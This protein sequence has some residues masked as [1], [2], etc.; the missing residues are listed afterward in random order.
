MESSHTPLIG[1][2]DLPPSGQ[3]DSLDQAL[4]R[5]LAWTGAARW[6]AQLATWTATILVARLLEKRDFGIWAGAGVYIGIVTLLSE[7]GIGASVVMLRDLTIRQIAQVNGF[8]IATGVAGTLLTVVLAHP[9]SLFYR[10]PEVEGVMLAMAVIFFISSFRIVPL[11]LLQKELRFRRLAAIDAVRALL[12]ASILVAAAAAGLRY[13]ALVVGAISGELAWTLMI[14]GHRRHGLGWPRPSSIRHALSFSTDVAVGRLSWYLYSNSDFMI[15]GRRLGQ[16]ALGAYSLA[17]NLASVPVEKVSSIVNSVTPAFL[18][19]VQTDKA[20]LRRYLLSLTQ[21]ISLLAF[22]AAIGLALVADSFVTAVLGPRWLP[23]VIPLRLLAA[24][25]TVRSIGP[26]LTP[27]LNAVGETRFA[28]VNNVFALVLMPAGFLV[29]SRWGT[30]GIAAG[31]L[32]VHPLILAVLFRRVSSRIDLPAVEY[33]R[34][35]WPALSATIAMATVVVG[36]RWTLSSAMAPPLALV[37]EGVAG[38]ITYAVLLLAFHR[39][40]VQAFRRILQLARS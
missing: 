39:S 40:R 21:G 13:W 1:T 24:Y 27:V 28:A 33:A 25:T 35:L 18:S 29:G 2:K 34:A 22:P 8:A 15:A 20:E 11:A 6:T 36:V 37:V 26:I 12:Q 9:I 38:A 16:D 4:V 5:G 3:R 32:F 23:A 19:A 14:L 30:A 17:W 31:W 7:F 10:T